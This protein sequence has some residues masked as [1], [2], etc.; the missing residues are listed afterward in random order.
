MAKEKKKRF[1]YIFVVLILIALLF[2]GYNF[3]LNNKKKDIKEEKVVE[4]IK[5]QDEEIIEDIKE[6]LPYE[7]IINDKGIFKDYYEKAYDKL[8]S[9]SL[10]EKINQIFFFFFL[11][12]A[13]TN[14]LKQYQFGGYLLFG[15][16]VVNI[17]KEDLI[18]KIKG[19]Q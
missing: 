8:Q 7:K 12:Y 16:D 17:T 19:Y 18:N 3:Y 9:M 4:K 2:G 5:E 11:Q 10:D 1:K 14:V 6:E 13:G 15:R